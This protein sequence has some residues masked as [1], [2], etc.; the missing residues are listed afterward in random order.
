MSTRMAANKLAKAWRY[1]YNHP[2]CGSAEAA[3]EAERAHMAAA[4][5]AQHVN[6]GDGFPSR[7]FGWQL[8]G[9]GVR[10]SGCWVGHTVRV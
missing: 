1:C 7:A 6:P 5:H 4:G 9:S 3:L 10:V 2:D 8:W